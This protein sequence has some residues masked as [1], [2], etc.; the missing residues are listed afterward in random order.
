[1]VKHFF[2]LRIEGVL[3]VM[4]LVPLFILPHVLPG[5]VKVIF[6]AEPFADMITVTGILFFKKYGKDYIKNS[7][8]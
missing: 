5:Q 8:H 4:H 7:T 3:D 1:M 2:V 6:L